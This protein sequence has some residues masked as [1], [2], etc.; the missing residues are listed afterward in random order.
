VLLHQILCGGD[1]V[2]VFFDTAVIMFGAGAPHP[3]RDLSGRDLVHAATCRVHGIDV[4]VGPDRGFD[5]VDGP[6]RI[7][8][9]DGPARLL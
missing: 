7:D 8:P 5:E 9:A 1:A 2:S 6:S 4:I 3:L